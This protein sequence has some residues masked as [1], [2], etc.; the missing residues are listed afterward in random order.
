MRKVLT[1]IS[2]IVILLAVCLG[3][4]GCGKSVKGDETYYLYVYDMGTA[5]FVKLPASVTFND[6]LTQFEYVFNDGSLS[7]RG[8]ATHETKPDRYTLTC[9]KDAISVVTEKYEQ[10]LIASGASA[11]EINDYKLIKESVTPQ[12]QLLYSD[13]YLFSARSV[14]L[15]HVAT[16]GRS[17]VFEGE[18]IMTGDG[19][20][21]SLK[22]G[23]LYMEENSGDGKFT[24]KM[25]YYTVS[26]GIMTVT[27]TDKDGK[28]TYTNGVLDRKKYL[29][30]TVSFGDEFELV[31]TDFEEQVESSEWLKMMQSELSSYVGKKYALLTDEFY[32]TELD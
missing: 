15:F 12:M 19:K 9:S 21:V 8:A 4:F 23:T 24:V 5:S 26:N 17:D 32:S 29:M 16:S 1:F 11:E 28:E 10:Q 14:E 6:D 18:F 13:G 3:S 22:G 2:L 30:V 27:L 7:I 31:G 20:K 25:G